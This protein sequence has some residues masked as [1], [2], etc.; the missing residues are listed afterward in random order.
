[1]SSPKPN[2]LFLFTDDQRYDTIGE[3][4][5]EEVIT[6]NLDRLVEGGTTF[7][8]ASIMGGISGAI[9]KNTSNQNLLAIQI[10][11]YE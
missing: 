5:N 3:L 1:M 4:G 8:E 9:S 11:L 6:P 10:L 7:T 2:I